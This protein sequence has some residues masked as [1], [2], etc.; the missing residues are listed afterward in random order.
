MQESLF[1]VLFLPL[2]LAI[3]MLGMG[4][5][6]VANDFKRVFI[7][8]KA[9]AVGLANQIILLP[10][11]AFIIS[12]LFSLAPEIAVGLM[13][14]SAAPGGV[15]SNLIS[16]LA[17]GDTAL[18]ITLTAIS[19]FITVITTPF[20]VKF[21][22]AHFMSSEHIV[23]LD[24]I[25]TIKTIL[26][27]TILPVVIGMVVREKKP[28]F[29]KR[30]QGIVRKVST[31]FLLLI[32]LGALLKEKANILPFFQQAGG[33]SLA[34]FVVMVSFGYW[35]AKLFKLST[36]QAVSISIETGIQNGSLAIFIAISI[37]GNSKMSIT[38]AIYSLVMLTLSFLLVYYFKRSAT[39][40][41]SKE[42]KTTLKT[43]SSRL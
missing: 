8:P 12:K 2:A 3:I 9:V 28:N 43:I 30:M 11:I 36:R 16:H 17:N 41:D 42:N 39:K 14:L 27:I 7:Y 26:A 10:I 5:S 24:I 29:A 15:T 38:P 18:S 23:R 31:I 33:P 40:E 32:I 13:L 34:L 6:L 21:A 1:T 25:T 20:I 35:S 4:L 37:L 19:S 22:L